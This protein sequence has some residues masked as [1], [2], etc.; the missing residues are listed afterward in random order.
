MQVLLSLLIILGEETNDMIPTANDGNKAEKH[1]APIQWNP[2]QDWLIH[3]PQPSNYSGTLSPQSLSLSRTSWTLSLQ[4]HFFP[5]LFYYSLF[6]IIDLLLGWHWLL[7]LNRFQAYI[8]L[9]HRL[10]IALCV[11]C[12]K[13]DVLPS[14]YIWPPSPFTFLSFSTKL[15]F[16]F[17]LLGFLWQFLDQ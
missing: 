2:G 10:F 8:S 13:W 14:L 17:F 6:F 5:V 12:P 3:P 9:I 1:M 4:V 7:K 15:P 16:L 11:Y